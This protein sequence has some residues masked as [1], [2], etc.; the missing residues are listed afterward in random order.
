ME[1][2]IF[3][4]RGSCDQVL[5]V[6]YTLQHMFQR[7]YRVRIYFFSGGGGGMYFQGIATFS[8]F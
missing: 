6:D 8:R 5:T 1:A 4:G 2:N 7:V 3:Q